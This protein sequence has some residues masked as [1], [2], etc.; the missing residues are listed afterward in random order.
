MI[1][2]CSENIAWAMVQYHCTPDFE[3][4]HIIC[5]YVFYWWKVSIVT[6]DVLA[7]FRQQDI[8]SA[9]AMLT[10]TLD[11]IWCHSPNGSITKIF[12]WKKKV[13][14]ITIIIKLLYGSWSK[15]IPCPMDP[16][17][18]VDPVQRI[19]ASNQ[20][21][22][23]GPSHSIQLQKWSQ[24]RVVLH[25]G[26]HTHP[27]AHQV[28]GVT[29]WHSLPPHP[30]SLPPPLRQILDLS[31]AMWWGWRGRGVLIL[32]LTFFF[33]QPN[34]LGI[35]LV[36]QEVRGLPWASYFIYLFIFVVVWSELEKY[37]KILNLTIG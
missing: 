12:I 8:W 26:T 4:I 9:V 31:P 19:W 6:A 32:L 7:S 15:E 11:T 21:P 35:K 36:D 29:I 24:V 30:L 20:T 27:C 23:Y 16:V 3:V 37:L 14:G 18:L 1:W 22:S 13:K 28:P 17:H 10:K 2:K 34:Q 5:F 33:L 25:T